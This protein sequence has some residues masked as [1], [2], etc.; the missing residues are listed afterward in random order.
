MGN[1]PAYRVTV[2]V[3]VSRPPPRLDFEST[4]L[5]RAPTAESLKAAD[6]VHYLPIAALFHVRWR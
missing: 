3:K 1:T 6:A 4:P 5:I 2:P